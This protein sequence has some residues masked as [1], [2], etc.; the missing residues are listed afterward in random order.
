MSERKSEEE[1][2]ARLDRERSEALRA[3]LK[4]ETEAATA[5]ARRNLFGGRCGRC[6]GVM[7]R[8]V[9]RGVEIDACPDCGAVL[10]DRSD[11]TRL[12]GVDQAGIIQAMFEM[13]H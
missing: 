13:F 6:G 11:L 10:L 8:R 3:I 7:A 5:E 1:Y 2:F 9:F 4:G 12:A